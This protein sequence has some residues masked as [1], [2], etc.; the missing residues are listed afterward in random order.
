MLDFHVY[1]SYVH[2]HSNIFSK[3]RYKTEIEASTLQYRINGSKP[4]I[5]DQ[6][7]NIVIM[8]TRI[9]I[10]PINSLGR[11]P[12]RQ[13][14]P[15]AQILCLQCLQPP[16]PPPSPPP[17]SPDNSLAWSRKHV[18]GRW[19]P[20]CSRIPPKFQHTLMRDSVRLLPLHH[21]QNINLMIRQYVQLP[22]LLS[23]I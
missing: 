8:S 21:V 11:S 5:E 17:N 7:N 13:Q 18:P 19:S 20:V 3:A 22:F 2:S 10:M 16:S 14:I 15:S 23:I 4:Q 9:M 6:R 1:I 12:V